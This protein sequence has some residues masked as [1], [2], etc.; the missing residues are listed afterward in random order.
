V[1]RFL[2]LD[3]G[4]G[5]RVGRLLINHQA[6]VE[7]FPFAFKF[8]DFVEQVRG[9]VG[10]EDISTPAQATGSPFWAGFANQLRSDV[11]FADHAFN[12]L[13]QTAGI[14][15]DPETAFVRLQFCKLLFRDS[16]W[17]FIDAENRVASQEAKDEHGTKRRST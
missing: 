13:A 9:T 15:A 4:S 17:V 7:G 5:F 6:R 2:L 10:A 8:F 12:D 14:K 11:S 1:Q 16:G 3:D